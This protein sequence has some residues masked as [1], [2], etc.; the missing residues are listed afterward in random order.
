MIDTHDVHWIYPQAMQIDEAA[1]SSGILSDLAVCSWTGCTPERRAPVRPSA[2]RHP[3]D[4][5]AAGGSAAGKVVADYYSVSEQ[6]PQHI[7]WRRNVS[8]SN[9]DVEVVVER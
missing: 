9:Y 2:R 7:N 5:A 3:G 6:P 4:D 8:L 1:S